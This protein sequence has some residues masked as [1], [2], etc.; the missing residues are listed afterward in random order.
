MTLGERIIS[1][2]LVWTVRAVEKTSRERTTREGKK[3]M[4][5]WKLTQREWE[6]NHKVTQETVVTRSWREQYD[7]FYLLT[8]V[9]PIKAVVEL[10]QIIR[11]WQ[12]VKNCWF[13]KKLTIYR[14]S[15]IQWTE[16]ST[17]NSPEYCMKAKKLK[18]YKKWLVFTVFRSI[19]HLWLHRV[20]PFDHSLMF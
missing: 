8:F 5:K 9:E 17:L 20:V 2:V 10:N 13:H 1:S 12:K 7:I 18:S 4:W 11:V 19:I 16:I 14:F 3:S 15:F 6:D